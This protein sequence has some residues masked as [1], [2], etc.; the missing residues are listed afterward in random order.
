MTDHH[1]ETTASRLPQLDQFDFHQRLQD[2]TGAALVSFTSPDCG[3]CHHLRGV[4][5]AVRRLEPDWQV[6]EVDVQRDPGLAY[7]FEVF[8]LPTVFLFND[9]QFHCRLDAEARTTAIIAT[10]RNALRQPA[11]EAP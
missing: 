3:G 5:K 9:G 7:E 1:P 2:S 11:V 10:T 4:L 8:H 6:F